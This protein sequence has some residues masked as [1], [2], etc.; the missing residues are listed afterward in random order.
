MC[1]LRV[2]APGRR[3]LRRA[4]AAPELVVVVCF[5]LFRFLFFFVFLVFCLSFYALMVSKYVWKYTG[6]RSVRP[7]ASNSSTEVF[8]GELVMHRGCIDAAAV[9][10]VVAS[11]VSL[12]SAERSSTR[13]QLRQH[14]P[15]PVI[16]ARP[17]NADE[18][19]DDSGRRCR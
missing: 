13:P 17:V 14:T 1:D 18:S 4:A 7:L 12:G 8:S 10:V 19:G 11:S 16:G 9:G 3:A 6:G 5:L 15:S 2:A